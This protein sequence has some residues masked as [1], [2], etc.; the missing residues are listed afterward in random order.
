MVMMSTAHLGVELLDGVTLGNSSLVATQL[1]LTLSPQNPTLFLANLYI[2]FSV[3]LPPAYSITHHAV[4]PNL[5]NIH[6]VLLVGQK[7][8]DLTNELTHGL[9]S[10]GA[11]LG[12]THPSKRGI[13]SCSHEKQPSPTSG[14][15]DPS[16][17]R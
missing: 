6:H 11:S 1:Q 10:L 8:A 5:Q 13:L 2:F 15:Y 17:N 9:H 14:S 7:S 4:T 12:I 16:P 3:L